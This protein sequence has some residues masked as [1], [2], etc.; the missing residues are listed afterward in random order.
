[1]AALVVQL[2]MK[3]ALQVAKMVLLLEQRAFIVK[4][5][6]ETC[7]LKYVC[8]TF[9]Q[10][11]PNSVS[12]SNHAILNLILKNLKMNI[13]SMIYHTGDGHLW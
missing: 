13:H 9:I 1:M 3:E 2:R 12:P 8:D 7:L 4:W 6:Y 5:Y 10:E 11:F